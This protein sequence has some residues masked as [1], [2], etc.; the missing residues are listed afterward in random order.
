VLKISGPVMSPHTAWILSKSL[1]TL[2]IRMDRHCENASKLASF[3][4]KNN[5]VLW[6]RYPFL[7]SHP[8]YKIAKKQMKSGG[9]LISFELKGGM[10]RTLRFIN[11]LTLASI[12]SNLGDTR[13][14]IT[15]P[16]TTT[17]CKLSADERKY[18]GVTDG[19]VRVSVGLEY[20]DDLINDFDQAI[21]KSKK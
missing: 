20:I 1:E 11:A 21:A 7:P 16:A 12:T 3:L 18:S 10:K 17:H 14:I 15:H 6:I 5:E 9:G 13:T 2:S 4:E 8:Q 19:M